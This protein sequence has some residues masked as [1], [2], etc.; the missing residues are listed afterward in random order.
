MTLKQSKPVCHYD[1]L[2]S[3]T[4][5]DLKLLMNGH[6]YL[7]LWEGAINMSRWVPLIILNL[8]RSTGS[9]KNLPRAYVPPPLISAVYI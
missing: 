2:D 9:P 7:I 3:A 8:D 4:Q 1:T 6:V 5:P